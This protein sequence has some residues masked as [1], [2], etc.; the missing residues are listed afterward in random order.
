MRGAAWR[1][2]LLASSALIAAAPPAAAADVMWLAN[3]GSSDFNTAANWTP[4]IVPSTGDTAFFGASSITNLSFSANVTTL[5]WTFNAGAPNYTTTHDRIITFTGTG[6]EVNGG[7][8][9]IVTNGGDVQFVNNTTAGSATLVTNFGSLL[10]DDNATAG[11]ASITS[12]ELLLFSDQSTAGSANIINQIDGILRFDSLSSAGSAIITT[13]A[14]TTTE[15][16]GNSTG[17]SARFITNANG[18]FSISQLISAGMTAGSIE[19]AG[20][21]QLGAKQ[22]TA[23]G[24]GGSTEVA[25]I[26]SGVGGSLVKTGAGTLTLS[27]G[28]TYTGGTTINAGVLQLGNGGATGSIVGNVLNNATLAF[29]R[30]N[31]YQFDGE[32]SGTG[33]VQQNGAGT[34]ILTAA[35]SYAGGTTINA[36]VLQLGNAGATG[37][38]VGNVL[39]N[40]TLVFNRSNIYQFDGEISG[41]G[42]VQQNGGG[43]TI[44]TAANTYAGG[45]TINAGVLQLGNAGAT[46]SIVG[47]VLNNATLVFNRSNVYQFDGE[48][49]G[50]GGVQQNGGGT[51]ILAAANSYAG[52]TTINAGVLQL[53]NAGATGSIVG[54][55]LNNATLVFNRS[56]LY[57]FD[58]EISGTGAV[59]QNGGGTTIL[60]AANSYAGGTTINAGVLQL[61]NGGATGSIVGNVLNNA[62]LVF[63]RSNIYQFDGEISGTGAVQQNGGGTT[64][65]TA[66]NSYAGGTTISAGVLQLG[67]GGTTGS[68]VGNVL[69]NAT[70]VFNRSN[71]YQFDG[72]I[73]GT[74]GVQQNGVGTTI[75]TA[76]NSYAG[77]TTVNSGTLSV[78]GSIVNS[79]LT[80]NAGGTLGGNGTVGTTTINGGTLA[81]G[82]SIG[83]LSVQGNLVLTAA[84]AYIVEVS[85]AQ[86][87]RTNVTG[88]AALAGSVQAV[89]GPGSYVP[90]TYTIL[91]ADGG[92]SGTFNGFTTAGLPAG[93]A[94]SI[95]YTNNDVI[96]GLTAALGAGTSMNENQQNV[97]TTLNTFFNGG[98]A[99]PP[100][101]L[102]VFGLTGSN[103]TN[104]LTL[105]S[106]EAATGSQQGALS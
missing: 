85:P 39:N 17:G 47:N 19:G 35:N 101:F 55:V 92:L 59:Q 12:S 105:L 50:T 6:I 71:I 76:A 70:L 78:N 95:S 102:N 33:A 53:G 5:G 13:E 89:F 16:R 65:L 8:I 103:L 32:I 34:T 22:L 15:F 3:P 77:A 82:N 42:G 74:G 11:T 68:I 28:N 9:S 41:T 104:A 10:F 62:T 30:S 18:V 57:Q 58:G 73:S 96:L 91:H 69:N 25:G 79:A 86:A 31:I 98:G 93:F 60:A 7:G 106:G 38:I 1:A 67:D 36:G 80:V 52:G 51:T 87:D 45:T 26:I 100:N 49:S 54:N 2:A 90:R 48:I 4:A 14:G 23:G 88:T 63:N 43:T 27:G 81:P 24:N 94:V 56:N 29:N 99:L 40:A 37:S 83:T 21:Y 84:A 64:I 75:L 97:A 44:L 61:G 46:G 66:A 20:S 72:E